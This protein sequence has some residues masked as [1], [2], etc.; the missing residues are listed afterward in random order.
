MASKSV[1]ISMN[2]P[3]SPDASDPSS[4]VE[5][6]DPPDIEAN[7][8]NRSTWRRLVFML[9]VG[10]I[11]AVSRPVVGAVV[12]LQFLWVLFSGEVNARLVA[13]GHSL[14]LYSAEVIDYLCYATDERP[15][16]FDKDWPG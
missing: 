6:G 13:L 4:G 15:F 14:A 7:L 8:K 10:A 1:A 2:D 16:P 5:A 12:A 11:Y 3:H 9:I